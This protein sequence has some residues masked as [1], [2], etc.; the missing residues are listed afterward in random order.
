MGKN[1]PKSSYYHKDNL[2]SPH[3]ENTFNKSANY[4]SNLKI[5]YSPFI[6]SSNLANSSCTQLS[7]H[8]L[9]KFG[10]ERKKKKNIVADMFSKYGKFTRTIPQN[11]ATLVHFF[12]KKSFV[13]VR[14]DFFLSPS[15]KRLPKKTIF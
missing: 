1:E 9:H 3:L 15:D 7:T 2:K 6:L 8:L 12:T 11:L 13:Q 14:L 5:L 4:M 10:K